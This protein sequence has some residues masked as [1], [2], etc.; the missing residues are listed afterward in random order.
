MLHLTQS[1]PNSL[2]NNVAELRVVTGTGIA[3]LSDAAIGTELGDSN[4]TRLANVTVPNADTT[5]ENANISDT[6]TRISFNSR[7]QDVYARQI[8]ESV[9]GGGV[10]IDNVKVNDD[11][12]DF[13]ERGSAP[14]TPSTGRWKIYFKSS[15]PFIV[16]DAGN[17][18]KI[19]TGGTTIDRKAPAAAA[20]GEAFENSEDQT[21]AFKDNQDA[22]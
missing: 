14:S 11:A 13:L 22:Y 16:D 1:E 2:K 6:R 5:I 9:S 20:A 12:L 15:G 4:W 3:A 8:K 17:V 19:A 7:L 10:D 18:T 21:L